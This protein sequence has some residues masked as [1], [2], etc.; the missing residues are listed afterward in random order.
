MNKLGICNQQRNGHFKPKNML[1]SAG[2]SA[3]NAAPRYWQR[4]NE[5]SNAA[6]NAP[7][8]CQQRNE[9][10]AMLAM[11]QVTLLRLLRPVRIHWRLYKENGENQ[12]SF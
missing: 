8:C 3:M 7:R 5:R 11:E 9:R 10:S 2:N 4:R 6:M 12:F 1:F